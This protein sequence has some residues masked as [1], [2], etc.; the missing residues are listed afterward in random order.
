MPDSSCEL[1]TDNG[2]ARLE[3]R[4]RQLELTK[5]EFRLRVDE[6]LAARGLHHSRR[7]TRMRLDRVFLPRMRRP[8][9]ELTRI[10]LASALEWRLDQLE[11]ALRGK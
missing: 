9:S 6:V 4:R 8:I 11:A 10:V 7:A 3:K 5:A 2:V 1:L